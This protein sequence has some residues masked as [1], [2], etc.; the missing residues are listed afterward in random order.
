MK[1]LLT[2]L[3]LILFI[4]PIS[5]NAL[6]KE[7]LSFYN[8]END[9]E[10]YYGYPIANGNE[11]Y[12]YNKII[13][14][15]DYLFMA[16]RSNVFYQNLSRYKDVRK[17]V[18]FL[19]KNRS[20]D[21]T[22]TLIYTTDKVNKVS[23]TVSKDDEYVIVD[24]PTSTFRDLKIKFKSKNIY[25]PI[26]IKGVELLT[27]NGNIL[28]DQDVSVYT[29]SLNHYDRKTYDKNTEGKVTL[30]GETKS[31]N[32]TGID[33]KTPS[34]KIKASKKD[35]N[36][37][38][39][40]SK[41]T[42]EGLNFSFYDL[43]SGF[44]GATIY[45]CQDVNNTCIPRTV[46]RKEITSYNILNGTYYI[47]YQVVS[48]S[49]A[50]S[51]IY[52]FE[53]NVETK[54]PEAEIEVLKTKSRLYINSDEWSSEDVMFRVTETSSMKGVTVYYCEDQD[55]TCT[56][57]I[58]VE[59][60]EFIEQERENGTYY[61]RY[62]MVNRSNLKSTVKS[63]KLK[64]DKDIPKVDLKVIKD[65]EELENNYDWL[66]NYLSY[67]LIDNS[68]GI[69]ERKI[70]YC[71]DLNNIC[72]PNIE[73]NS[74]ELIDEFNNTN[75]KYYFR[76]K[77]ENESGLESEIYSYEA[78]VDAKPTSV[79]LIARNDKE[80][81]QT[82]SWSNKG[83]TFEFLKNDVY[84]KS[85]I[86]YCIDTENDCIPDTLIEENTIIKDYVDA[87]GIYYIR[88]KTI[89]EANVES[90]TFSYTAKV[91]E[92]IPDVDIEVSNGEKV[93][94]DTWQSSKV[95]FKFVTKNVGASNTKIYYC[96]DENNTCT[97][98]I[99]IENEKEVSSDK[100]GIYYIRYYI[101][102]DLNVKSNIKTFIVKID[103]VK[104]ICMIT[105]STNEWTNQNITLTI[106]TVYSGI[107]NVSSYSWD[108]INFNNNSTKEISENGHIDGY[109]KNSAG[110]VSKCSIEVENIDKE[111]PSCELTAIGTNNDDT[112]VDEVTIKF[113]KVND[114]YEIDS[115]GLYK[116]DG[117]KE[118]KNNKNSNVSVTYRGYIKDKAGNTNTCDISIIK[119]SKLIVKYDNNGGSS[120]SSKEVNYNESY[121]SLCTPVRTGYTFDGWYL[122]DKKIDNNTKVTQVSN[123]TLKAKWIVNKYTLTYDVS[124]CSNITKEYGNSWGNL[125]TPHKDGYIFA[126]WYKEFNNKKI[127][128]TETT[129]VTGSINVYAKWIKEGNTITYDNDGGYG[130][131]KQIVEKEQP[132]GSM[133]I[134]KKEDSIFDGWY[135][136]DNK[137]MQIS[138]NNIIE[139]DIEL[140]AKWKTI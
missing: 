51:E 59:G 71:K 126:G 103:S 23:K 116:F 47:R 96:I 100:E 1:K 77:I 119:N 53:A 32:I 8:Y 9:Y 62:Y 40:S 93:L 105:K 22:I 7:P 108:G 125:C 92:E 69:S 89:N 66:D 75:G 13:E 117:V 94:N 2:M 83:L 20:Q 78:K 101:E 122:D 98:D 39:K 65:N 81:V 42:N 127:L 3:L 28:T 14:F 109:V 21:A 74:N 29:L 76:Y 134:P 52:S 54:T 10:L 24:I 46:Y 19:N 56:P 36:E 73:I 48:N 107:S 17:I 60:T 84:S 58:K 131:D 6:G 110:V 18:V 90:E 136:K 114:N 64:I 27:K 5:A 113:A 57:N 82:D 33:K 140:I 91:D 30:N 35:S 25:V 70:T 31:F 26:Q 41:W 102:N 95:S 34:V 112:Y 11:E 137:N 123:H 97:P 129:T 49:R 67:I 80:L 38:V 85:D 135:L 4:T 99:K 124:S 16:R 111:K 12:E 118:I 72:I 50:K 79:Y 37:E 139:N 121:G 88:Y 86:Y 104:P 43:E 68:E 55:N 138:E 130:C 120:C 61:I 44:S 15:Q 115:Y 63:F 106:N 132:I 133:C 45:Y 128:I 87:K